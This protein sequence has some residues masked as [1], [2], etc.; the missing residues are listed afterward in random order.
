MRQAVLCARRG[1]ARSR[2]LS[3]IEN[4]G[5][6]KRK[7]AM[8]S[9][10]LRVR[11]AALAAAALAVA[12]LLAACGSSSSS[13]SSASSSSGASGVVTG[14]FGSGATFTNDFNPFSPS[15][16]D[17]ANGMIYEPLLFFN[18]AKA[19][20]VTPWLATSYS[21]SDGG[22]SIT[23]Q[24]RHGVKW[25]D[26][27]PFTSADVA[28]NF[29]LRKS[30]PALNGFGLPIAGATASGPYS[31][32]VNFTSSA[33]TQLY[34]IAGKTFMVPEHIW[35]NIS[36]PTTYLTAHP[37]GTGAYEVSKVTPQVLEMT[38]NPHY[39]MPGLPK[40]K[41]YRFLTYSGNDTMDTAVEDGDL[42][43]SGAFIANI[44]KTYLARDSKY[45]LVDLPLAVDVL[46]PNMVKGPTTSPAVRQ[47]ISDAIDRNYI[48]QSVYNG[49]A[50]PTDPE[51]LLV[52]NFNSVASP[53]AS[54]DSFGGPD[55]AAAKKVL[56]AAGYKAG[57]HGI[58]NTP[59]GT[60]LAVD[61]KVVTGYT[62]YIS[63]LQI[64]T[65]E[66]AAAGIK[67]TYTQEAYS[68]WAADQDSGNFQLLISSE[69]YTPVPYDYYYGMLDSLGTKPLGTGTGVSGDYG[70]YTNATVDGLLATIAGTTDTS[71]QN[72]AF[73]KIESIVKSQLPVIPLMEAQDE[74]EFNG[75]MVS[76]WPTKTNPYAAPAIWLQPDDAWV[77]DRLAPAS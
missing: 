61:V 7:S 26:G 51:A 77:A 62:D 24:L 74:I 65:S 48:S 22:K 71:A 56:A 3:A 10:S 53:E 50:P 20:T 12:G 57:A 60:P 46:I 59:S 11:S 8:W 16:Q 39:Y 33:Y 15:V 9:R 38:A 70:R 45:A 29:N 14:S 69:G 58:F 47:A 63:I 43:W 2:R 44:D 73:A 40:V 13:S 35:K 5:Q 34:L 25:S 18:T 55:P 1:P 49:Y 19:G 41:T 6:R 76:G 72:A 68:V 17:P 67:M 30:S 75:K 21:W 32:T 42:G 52:P 37:V 36:N 23:F 4:A 64:M 28:Y 54:S 66:L 27:Q 31:V